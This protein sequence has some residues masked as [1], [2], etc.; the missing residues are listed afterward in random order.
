MARER[1]VFF[2][3]RQ[4]ILALGVGFLVWCGGLQG[5]SP[6]EARVTSVSSISISESIQQGRELYETGQYAQAAV[7]WQQAAKAYQASGDKLN[8]AMALSNLA[9]AYQ[10]LGNWSQANQAIATSL[11]LLSTSATNPQQAQVL[12]QAWNNQGSLQFAQGQAEQA[13]NS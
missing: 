13:L 8:Q 1:R 3:S 11:K 4:P 9:L 6:V 12:A 2:R 10:Q 7:V 5:G